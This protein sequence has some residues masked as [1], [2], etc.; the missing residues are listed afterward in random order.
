MNRAGRICAT[1]SRFALRQEECLRTIARVP[2]G[3]IKAV[4][5]FGKAQ[6]VDEIVY[7]VDGPKPIGKIQPG[8]YVIGV[9]G[10][11]TEVTGV[12]PQ[13][14]KEIVE[15]EF[16]DETVVR[17]CPEHLWNVQ[18]KAQKHRNKPY[19]TVQIGALA[20]DLYDNSGNKKWFV[21]VTEPVHFQRRD[22]CV[23]P[24]L[25]G[26]LLGDGGLTQ[27]SI[28]LSSAD[29]EIVDRVDEL[30]QPFGLFVRYIAQYDWAI[31]H[32]V[33]RRKNKLKIALQ[34]LGVCVLSKDKQIPDCY[35]HASFEQRLALLRGL[36]DTDGTIRKNQYHVEF[37]PVASKN[38]ADDVC[39]LVRSLGGVTRVKPQTYAAQPGKTYYRVAVNLPVNPFWLPRKA[40]LWRN[41]TKQGKTKAV[42]AVRP[43]GNAECAC[44]SV[45]ADDG[46]YLTNGYTVTHN[47]TLIGAAALLF[48]E[49]RIDVVTKSVDVAERIKRSLRRFIPKVGMIGDGWKDR[50]RVTVITAGS[51][52]H[53]DGEADF[54]FADEVHQLATINSSPRWPAGIGTRG[55]SAL[56]HAV[57]APRQRASRAGA[58][59][60][61]D[62]VRAD[63]PAGRGIGAGRAGSRALASDA[64]ADKPAERFGNRV[65]R[66]R[67]GIWTNHERNSRIAAAVKEYSDTD[68]I[69]ILVETI[70]HA[71]ASRP[72]SA[73][74]HAGVRLHA[75]ARSRCLQAQSF[76]ARGVPAAHGR[77]ET[78]TCAANLEAGTLRRVIAT[79]I[80]ATGVRFRAA[81]RARPGRRPRQRHRGRTRAR[82]CEPH[83]HR[84][85]RDTKE[86]GEVLDCMDTFDSTFYRKSLGR[87]NSYKLL[88]WEQNWHDAQRSWRNPGTNSTD[89]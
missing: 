29:K 63:V 19:Q 87:R 14:V 16:S 17:C 45:S 43:A 37:G 11:P 7:T 82:S 40:K 44:I 51:L 78:A 64:A 6:P 72:A 56:G 80:W 68:Q 24:Y 33:R 36:M 61:P 48:P 46:L 86:F 59:L 70:E 53:A 60:W 32:G 28:R 1:K 25:L 77:A 76:A 41:E 12:Y 58:A 31:T 75:A 54:L 57:R 47:T 52:G 85:R 39:D 65:A 74:F 66:K 35:K 67:H 8:D 22:L 3:I 4:T 89:A 79:D 15:I 21:P 73:R 5:G 2:C 88:G 34:K 62:G 13:G 69:L 42:V 49:A 71:V 18:T 84:T 55:T 26:V 38:L 23:D 81:R 27:N 83:L 10:Y 9:N 20:N 50:Q 30:V